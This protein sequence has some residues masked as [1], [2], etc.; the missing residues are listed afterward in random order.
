MVKQIEVV[1]Y[2]PDWPLL[3]KTEADRIQKA[4]GEMCTQ[5]HHVGSTAIPGLS[6]KPK[7]DIIAV[8]KPDTDPVPP[9]ESIGYQYKGEYNIPFHYGFSKRVGTFVNLHVFEENNPEIQLNLLF[10]DYLR[11]H[12][13]TRDHYQKLK[14]DLVSE[15]SSHVK[16]QSMFT[17]Y[18]L[19]KNAFIQEVL[20]KSGFD[21]LCLRFCTHYQEWEAA[22]A[23]R[24]KTF[25]DK[26]PIQDPYTWTFNHSDHIHFVL[27]QGSQVVGYAHIQL[28]PDNRAALRIIVVEEEYRNLKLGSHFLTLCEKWLKKRGIRILQT[29]ASPKAKNFYLKNH[30]Q[31][32]PFN[33]PE[34]EKTHPDDTA[35]GKYL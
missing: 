34:G 24:Q 5:I 15:A 17:G 33:D 35:L 19:G 18:N 21:G 4:L 32:M 23:L 29:E 27:Y 12:P 14:I 16:N 9:L 3:F 25:F 22:K 13:A 2:N 26:V 6:A 30:Y 28:W 11:E 8:I 7:I 10:R 31:E 1:P 20:K